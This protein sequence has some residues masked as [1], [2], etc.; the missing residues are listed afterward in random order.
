MQNECDN[1][2]EVNAGSEEDLASFLEAIAGPN[3]P[4]DFDK[5]QPLPKFLRSIQT[6]ESTIEGEVLQ[7][8]YVENGPNGGPKS[9][10]PLTYEEWEKF[11]KAGFP[12]IIS[13]RRENWGCGSNALEPIDFDNDTD[14]TFYFSTEAEPPT[15]IVEELRDQFPDLD[16][17]AFFKAHHKQQSGYY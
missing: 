3:G 6:R 8:W 16:F 4:L 12:S 11:A 17:V 9:E 10:R 13:W 1:R 2:I 7:N 5:I 15:Q 14:V